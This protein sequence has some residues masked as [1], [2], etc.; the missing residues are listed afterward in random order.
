MQSPEMGVETK[1]TALESPKKLIAARK[2]SAKFVQLSHLRKL[3]QCE[4]VAAICYRLRR[5]TVE[6]LLVRTR[7]GRW[8]FP[9]GNSEPGLTHAQA[10]ALEAFEEAGVHGRIEEVPFVCYTRLRRGARNSNSTAGHIVVNAYLCEVSWLENPQEFDR[11]PTWFPATKARRALKEERARD[12]ST[13]LTTVIDQA[14][15]RIQHKTIVSSDSNSK[16]FSIDKFRSM[17]MERSQ[18]I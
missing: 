8:I 3:Q 14:L 16:I 5:D 1:A 15:K 11:N 18:R 2:A 12:Y 13:E 10:A 17:R 6:F 9:K 7:G 4:Q